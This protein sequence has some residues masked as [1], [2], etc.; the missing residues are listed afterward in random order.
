VVAMP[1]AA[2]CGQRFWETSRGRL[3]GRR[4]EVK[5]EPTLDVRHIRTTTYSVA[6]FELP[7]GCNGRDLAALLHELAIRRGFEE[8]V[9]PEDSRPPQSKSPLLLRGL[10]EERE[11]RKKFQHAASKHTAVLG[12]VEGVKYESLP[13]A[14]DL[15]RY[16]HLALRERMRQCVQG[17]RLYEVRVFGYFDEA[18]DRAWRRMVES[19]HFVSEKKDGK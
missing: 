12:G 1:G 13:S 9:L 6:Y 3:L 5:V 16:G 2:T 8:G 7:A 18:T 19:F 15:R 17:D 11:W 4:C 14:E 10:L